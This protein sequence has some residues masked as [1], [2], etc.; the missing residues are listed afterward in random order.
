MKPPAFEYVR[1]STL[2]EA[3]QALADTTVEAKV[4]A[5]GQSLIPLLNF[6]LAF[7][8]RLV[9]IKGIAALDYIRSDGARLRIGAAT[10]TAT[11][12]RS[13]EVARHLPIL[14]EACHW[15]GHVQ[16]RNRG[17]I[18]GSIAHADPSAEI[19]ALCVLLDAE[20]TVRSQARTRSVKANGFFHGFLTTG[21]EKDEILEEVSFPI[22]P[23]GTR[24]GFR[25]FA[26]RRG[27]FALAG[28][29]CVLRTAKEGTV[30]EARTVLFGATDFPVRSTKAESALTGKRLNAEMIQETARAAT[31][32]LR[33]E[34]AGDADRLYRLEVAEVMLRRALQDATT[35]GKSRGGAQ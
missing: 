4:L 33:E 19:P 16:I 31:E 20:L 13:A 28:A 11:V 8:S 29:G 10:S 35:E 9:D 3:L 21:L 23:D 12:E 15:V 30:E 1:P 32:A 26:V 27:D 14:S 2:D 6:R 18:G 34:T 5:G 17:T 24:W 7:P 25:E 22:L